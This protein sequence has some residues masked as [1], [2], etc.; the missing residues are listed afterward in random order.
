MGWGDD[1]M[2]LGEANKVHEDNPDAVIHDG[3]EYSELWKHTP[4][5]VSPS[6]KGPERKIEVPRKPGG[7]RWYIKGWGNGKVLY[8]K[9]DPIP[10]PY[11]VLPEE[12]QWAL[13]ELEKAGVNGPFVLINPDTKNTTFANNK[14]WGLK[15]WNT[16]AEKLTEWG[17]TCVRTKPPGATRDVSGYVEYKV[18]ELEHCVNITTPSIRHAFAILDQSSAVVTSE[19]GLHHAAAALDKKAF[20][21]FGGVSSVDSTGYKNS[22]QTYYTYDHPLTPCGSQR[23]CQHC[24]EAMD[25][26]KPVTIA[27]DVFEYLREGHQ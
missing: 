1:L 11:E 23:D 22:N 27:V 14:Q 16:L 18:P 25:S 7:N 24:K 2:W 12:R 19:G 3:R 21:I 26:I 15:K 9:Y 5:V 17:V 13:E 8:K 4:W 20:V 6:Y 10:A